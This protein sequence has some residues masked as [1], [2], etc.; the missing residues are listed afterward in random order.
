MLLNLESTDETYTPR[1][2]V[3]AEKY[4][5]CWRI[6]NRSS[7]TLQYFPGKKDMLDNTMYTQYFGDK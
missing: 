7:N 4:T 2:V 1:N 5:T 3:L 6:S